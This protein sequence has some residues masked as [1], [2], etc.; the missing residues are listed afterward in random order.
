MNGIELLICLLLLFM[1]VPDFCRRIGRRALSFPLF[2]VIGVALGPLLREDLKTLLMEAGNVG[3]TL[4]LF[5][6]GL[7]IEL[8]ASAAIRR[9]LRFALPWAL[10]QYPAVVALAGAAG[11]NLT[12]ALFAAATI[13]GV[14]VG[15]AHAAWKIFPGLDEDERRR[16]LHVMVVLETL[17]ILTIGGE[18]ALLKSGLTWLLGA[19]LLVIVLVIV[20]VARAATHVTRLFQRVLTMATHWKTHLLV[21]LV[22]AVGAV[23][24]RLGL[25]APKTA[26]FLGLFMSRVEHEGKG[27][28]EVI[29]PIS[30]QFLIPLFFISLGI[31][32]HIGF[33][34]TVPGLIALG[35]AWLILGVRYLLHRRVLPMGRD[36]NAFLLLCPNLTM[37]ALGAATLHEADAP[38]Q[39]AS[40]LLLTG[41]LISVTSLFL[42]PATRAEPS[43]AS[44]APKSV[45]SA[46]R[47]GSDAI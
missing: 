33:V 9:A 11:L 5:E 18:A 34:L 39:H 3:F 25:A 41:V 31:Q 32:V 10:L 35:A 47:P 22:L 38:R 19:K 8:P 27:V 13:T 42:L 7:E 36:P 12:E 44:H 17:A 1:S 15:M 40:W 29:A 20:L 46:A 37:V 28:E 30:R 2:V 24:E 26:F 4:L 6:V 21:V 16:C 45:P 23:G 14:S 43:G